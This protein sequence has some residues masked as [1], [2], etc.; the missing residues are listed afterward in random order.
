MAALMEALPAGSTDCHTHAFGDPARF[1]FMPG[2]SYTPGLADADQLR[3]F[4]DDH[5]LA[6]VVVVQPSVY[7]TDN[8]CT[9]DAVRRM[10]GR[11]RAVVVVHPG[12]GDAALAGLHEAGARGVRLNLATT[13]AT[14]VAG[15]RAMVAAFARRLHGSAWHLQIFAGHEVLWALRGEL[16]GAGV[17]VVIDHFGLVGLKE[18]PLATAA[19]NI[20]H[21]VGGE[22]LHIKLSAPQRSVADPD[23]APVL[24]DLV[25]ALVAASPQRLLWGS[26]WPHPGRVRTGDPATPEAFEA[27]DDRRALARIAGWVRDEAALR[28]ILVDNPQALYGFGPEG[29]APAS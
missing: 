4:L 22:G 15:A 20:G 2:R 3:G 29:G 27:V 11:A 6:R 7:G 26:D 24:A 8:R 9:L 5:G 23:D 12:I 1:P 13:G 28:R 25:A 14:D 18:T 16:G 17:P 21:L 19:R 10:A